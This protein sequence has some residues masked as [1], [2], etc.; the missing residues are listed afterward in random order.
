MALIKKDKSNDI[1]GEGDKLIVSSK[2]A[3]P[4]PSSGRS[5]MKEDE[6]LYL[7]F[8]DQARCDLIYGE[9]GT[10]KTE[11]LGP[12]AKYVWEKYGKIS[13]LVSA[14]GGG[15]KPLQPYIDL[16]YIQAISINAV[17]NPLQIVM[18]LAKGYW[19]SLINGKYVYQPLT[20]D[21]LKGDEIKG[22]PGVGGGFFEGLT[23]FADMLMIDATYVP[24]GK[25]DVANFPEQMKNCKV[26]SGTDT[27][28]FAGRSH[29]GFI[30]TRIQQLVGL[31]NGLP[32]EKIVCTAL[33]EKGVDPETGDSCYGPKIIGKAATGKAPQWFGDCIH[34]EMLT[35]KGIESDN[36]EDYKMTVA[37]GIKEKH[38]RAYLKNHPDPATGIYYKAKTR[39]SSW[40]SDE[41]PA[42]FDMIL[43]GS[44]QKGINWLYEQED[45]WAL[46]AAEMISSSSLTSRKP[47]AIFYKVRGR[48]MSQGVDI[49]PTDAEV[50]RD[51]DE[52]D[53]MRDTQ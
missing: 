51:N 37:G 47:P 46:K 53:N 45:I 33:E 14:D 35:G 6:S 50:Q 22:I 44:E 16:G 18:A 10:G 4:S 26:T 40:V 8:G 30:Q 36:R 7:G 52:K 38:I 27:F 20:Q 29:Y 43:N 39:A 23:S 13:R 25:Q 28:E 21:I 3:S 42:Y 19:P 17:K 5:I 15:W 49:G 31:L 24:E 1:S 12:I 48:E 34:L 9:S 32:Y 11:N 2:V 41:V